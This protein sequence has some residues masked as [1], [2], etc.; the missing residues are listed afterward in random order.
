MDEEKVFD[1]LDTH[2][3][4]KKKTQNKTLCKLVTEGN[5]LSLIKGIYEKPTANNIL[6]HGRMNVFQ[7]KSR[8]KWRCPPFPLPLNIVLDAP[9]SVIRQRNKGIWNGKEEVKLLYFQTTWLLENPMEFTKQ[10]TRT[11]E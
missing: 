3:W 9:T 5:F 11:S 1:K 2:F 4:L 10:F 8:T 7:W 6:H